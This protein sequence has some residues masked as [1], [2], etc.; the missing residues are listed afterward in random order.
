MSKKK[1]QPS[2]DIDIMGSVAT[3]H[4]PVAR[5][6]GLLWSWGCKF[7]PG[8]RGEIAREMKGMTVE[9]G[10]VCVAASPIPTLT[11]LADL[12]LVLLC[13]AAGTNIFIIYLT[14]FCTPMH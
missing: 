9:W 6:Y 8:R 1:E 14:F 13:T 3:P 11:A 5:L 4:S 12:S 2:L 10:H 7:D